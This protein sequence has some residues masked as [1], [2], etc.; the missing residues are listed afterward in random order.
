MKEKNQISRERLEKY[1]SL[2]EQAL[3]KVRMKKKG[4]VDLHAVAEDFLQMAK[5]YFSD[6]KHFRDKGDMV[7]A[8][9][10]VA[11]AHAWLDA[12][13]RM[14]LF[15]TQGDTDLFASD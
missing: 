4:S 9:A 1:F 10:A 8:F 7:T 11:Y 12:G 13:V 6:A 3:Q 15:D 14:G 5:T 2:T